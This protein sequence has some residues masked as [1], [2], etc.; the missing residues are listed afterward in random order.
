MRQEDSKQIP[1]VIPFFGLSD[2]PQLRRIKGGNPLTGVRRNELLEWSESCENSPIDDVLNVSQPHEPDVAM[3][4][5]VRRQY[6]KQKQ[7]KYAQ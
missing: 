2:R 5:C 3:C 1:P 6:Q 4:V 7:K